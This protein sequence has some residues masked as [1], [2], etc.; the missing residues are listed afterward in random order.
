MIIVAGTNA[1]LVQFFLIK[2]LGVLV[3]SDF[4]L[5]YF[6]IFKN[7]LCKSNFGL[8]VSSLT[9]I[10]AFIKTAKYLHIPNTYLS[11]VTVYFIGF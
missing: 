6:K 7:N 5:K 4:Q 8:S 10:D 11:N 3:I 2:V 9:E 1:E